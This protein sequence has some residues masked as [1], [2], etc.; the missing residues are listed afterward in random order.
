MSK[1]IRQIAVATAPSGD[2]LIVTIVAVDYEDQ[3]WQLKRD[4]WIPLPPLPNEA[5]R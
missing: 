3:A 4:K 5:P 2:A 1:H